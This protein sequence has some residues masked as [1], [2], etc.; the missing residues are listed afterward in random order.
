MRKKSLPQGRYGYFLELHI[1]SFFFISFNSL[2][3]SL[4]PVPFNAQAVK[5]NQLQ[6]SCTVVISLQQSNRQS[7]IIDQSECG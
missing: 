3:K 5:Y 7:A 2:K 6:Y 4:N 1:E